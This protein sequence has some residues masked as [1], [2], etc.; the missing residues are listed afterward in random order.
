M[1]FIVLGENEVKW[2]SETIFEEKKEYYFLIG[3][4]ISPSNTIRIA[5]YD[6]LGKTDYSILSNNFK[7]DFSSQKI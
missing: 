5:Y 2:E 3:F 1:R 6:N 4:A 7:F